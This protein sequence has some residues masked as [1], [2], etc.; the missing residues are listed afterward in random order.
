MRGVTTYK[1]GH[2]TDYF[3]LLF[4]MDIKPTI[5]IATLDITV[6]RDIDLI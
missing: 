6:R 2:R 4:M 3:A 1:K 5:T